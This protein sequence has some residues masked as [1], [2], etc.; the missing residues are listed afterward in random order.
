MIV[1]DNTIREKRDHEEERRPRKRKR[2]GSEDEGSLKPSH[3]DRIPSSKYKKPYL[4]FVRRGDA[5][6]SGLLEHDP[7][8]F[9]EGP[10]RVVIRIENILFKVSKAC[11]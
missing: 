9:E 11:L 1:D 4:L 3:D 5:T 10:T 8:Y 7:V 2:V 6:E